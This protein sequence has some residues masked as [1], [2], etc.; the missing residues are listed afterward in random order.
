MRVIKNKV[1][2]EFLGREP[3]VPTDTS[4]EPIIG[5]TLFFGQEIALRRFSSFPP[6]ATTEGDFEEMPLLAGQG[7]GLIRDIKPA[8]EIIETMMGDAVLTLFSAGTR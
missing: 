7:V 8:K 5:K 4:A 2:N 1:V 3:E 6:I